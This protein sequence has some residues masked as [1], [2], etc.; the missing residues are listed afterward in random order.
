M[1]SPIEPP[2]TKL[3]YIRT[4]AFFAA[5]ELSISPFSCVIIQL[6]HGFMIGY[7]VNL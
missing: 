1:N 5:I 3:C 7:S 6:K 2:V 4:G